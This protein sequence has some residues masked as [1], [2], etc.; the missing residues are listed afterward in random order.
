[1]TR[2]NWTLLPDPEP[3][4]R[5]FP[6]ISVDDH[7][8]EPPDVFAGRMP[9]HLVERGP[10]IVEMPDGAE[11]WA[12]DNSIVFDLGLGVVAGRPRE[13]WTHD[14]L[15][16]DEMRR[17]CWD[18]HARVRDM[19]LDGV[20]ASVC[21]PSLAFGFAGRVLSLHKDRELG[22]AA[23]RAW[24][25]WM[26]EEWAGA[27]PDRFIPLQLPYMADPAIAGE[28][29]RRN[30]ELG[31]KAV[32]FVEAPHRL[33]LPPI[34][35]HDHWRPFLAACEETG[36]VVCLHTGSSGFVMQGSPGSS[37]NVQTSLFPAG[38]FTAAIDWTWGRIPILYPDLKI[39]LSEGGIGWVPMAIDRLNYVVEH[40]AGPATGDPWTADITPCEA[41]LRSFWFC[42]LDDPN[43]LH[44]R[45]EIGVDH[46]MFET[47]Y[48]HADSTWPG[49]QDL[50]RSRLGGLPTEEAE[51]I[52]FRNAAALFRHPLPA[53]D[54]A[55][56][57]PE[58]APRAVAGT[59]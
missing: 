57:T 34:I 28:E 16:F 20:W 55:A 45:H 25:Q 36:T 51:A 56:A 33:D 22:L 39:A 47:D 3:R 49:T 53:A 1:V 10:Q 42:M 15:R 5:A 37:L 19:D 24:N 44:A 14:P 43:T 50:L 26:I 2:R 27:Y 41:F 35:D 11:V 32:S 18:V 17:G 6:V 13:E 4:E 30:A 54:W 40:S 9:S 59:R 29:V 23:I 7:I 8:A 58:P 52:A 21:F 48:P 12:Y 38:A 46:I 31:F